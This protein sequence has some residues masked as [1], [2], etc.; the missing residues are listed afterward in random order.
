MML[1]ELIAVPCLSC[2]YHVEV[3]LVDARVQAY[4]RCPCCRVLIRLVD[5]D[6][7]MYGE[8]EEVDEAMNQLDQALRRFS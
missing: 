6:G 4:R 5:S 1:R 7:S 2:G 8:L 3:Q